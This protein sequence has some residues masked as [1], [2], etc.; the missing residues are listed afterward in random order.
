MTICLSTAGPLLI[1]AGETNLLDPSLPDMRFIRCNYNGEETVFIPGSS[2]KG[3]FRSRYEQLLKQL[4]KEVCDF[5]DKKTSCSQVLID[6]YSKKTIA[7]EQMYEESCAA[8]RLFGNLKMGGRIQFT[9]AYPDSVND[10]P[11]RIGKRNG[12]RINRLTGAAD[13]EGGALYDFEV[14]ESGMFKFQITLS[15]FARY[16]LALI[17]AILDDVN[18]GFVSFGLGTTRGNGKMTLA[19]REKIPAVYRYYGME[20]VTTLCGYS[21]KDTGTS[22]HVEK[23]M[24]AQVSNING[25]DRIFSSI[26]IDPD[27]LKKAIEV[28][29]WQK[30][31]FSQIKRESGQ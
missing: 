11:I 19:N 29:D 9:D 7:G 21:P 17:L 30:V 24:F 27:N 8:C 22:I 31:L 16:Q 3:V 23:E 20:P 14:V 28:E 10:N 25:Y 26:G 18:A 4:E 1:C 5:S 13:T 12:V 2:L 6:K 15:N